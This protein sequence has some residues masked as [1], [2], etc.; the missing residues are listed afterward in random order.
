M[1]TISTHRQKMQCIEKESKKKEAANENDI[2]RDMIPE[3]PMNMLTR[4]VETNVIPQ[5]EMKGIQPGVGGRMARTNVVKETETAV[6]LIETAT[7]PSP[8]TISLENQITAP[9]LPIRGGHLNI[10]QER[11]REMRQEPEIEI[12]MKTTGVMVRSSKGIPIMTETNVDTRIDHDPDLGLPW[13]NTA[14]LE[15]VLST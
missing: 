9:I 3:I 2:T 6:D 1:V 5:R 8:M 7:I 4:V 15:L 14:T 12:A 10:Q 11:T 13:K